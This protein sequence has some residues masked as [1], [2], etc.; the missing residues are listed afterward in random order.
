MSACP[1][2]PQFTHS[3]STIRVQEAVVLC[4]FPTYMLVF[5]FQGQLVDRPGKAEI[6]ILVLVVD[7]NKGFGDIVFCPFFNDFL[8]LLIFC[9]SLDQFIIVLQIR[10]MRSRTFHQ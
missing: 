3:I 9:G 1:W 5:S 2:Y 8:L 10:T 4:L 7:S 6:T